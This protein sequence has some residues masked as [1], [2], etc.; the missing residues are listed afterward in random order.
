MQGEGVKVINEEELKGMDQWHSAIKER[1]RVMSKVSLNPSLSKQ[2]DDI[3]ILCES[4]KDVP[5][6]ED[7]YRFSPRHTRVTRW[8]KTPAG[9][10]VRERIYDAAEYEKGLIWKKKIHSSTFSESEPFPNPI[11]AARDFMRMYGVSL[12]DAVKILEIEI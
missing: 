12:E 10:I 11:E 7:G 8:L 2:S 6:Y 1:W 5:E 3:K 4:T 9:T